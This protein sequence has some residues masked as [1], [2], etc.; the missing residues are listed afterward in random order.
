MLSSKRVAAAEASQ[1][2]PHHALNPACSA[3][4]SLLQLLLSHLHKRHQGDG[5]ARQLGLRLSGIN[6]PAVGG[7]RAAQ[8]RKCLQ[9]AGCSR[10]SM[11]LQRSSKL[12]QQG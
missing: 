9:A 2:P 5:R 11:S 4:L 7:G 1:V 3:V 8:R 10:L 12:V 6:A